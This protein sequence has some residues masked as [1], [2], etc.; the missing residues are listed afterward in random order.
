MRHNT[1]LSCLV[2]IKIFPNEEFQT[3]SVT[4]EDIAKLRSLA[5]QKL[6]EQLK[7]VKNQIKNVLSESSV[8]A[9][10]P[11]DC[12]ILFNIFYCFFWS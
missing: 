12:I 11:F 8:V 2:I 10:I 9:F 7:V 5:A 1:K 4:K 6:P 3:A